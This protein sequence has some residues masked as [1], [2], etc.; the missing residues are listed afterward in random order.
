MPPPRRDA[1]ARRRIL[2]TGVAG[3]LAAKL[4]ARLEADDRVD[5]IGGVDLVEPSH[6]LGRTEFIRADLR[7]PLV[8]KV[9]ASTRIDTIVH[10]AI[11][12]APRAAGGRSRMK[13]LNVIGTMQLLGAA[14]K[15]PR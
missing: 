15:T 1:P 2:V 9:I 14:Q 8:A 13:E 7:N 10:L 11:A 6:Q 4:C 5:Y 12:A 3:A